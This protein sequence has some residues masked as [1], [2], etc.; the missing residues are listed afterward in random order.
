MSN[1]S[2]AIEWSQHTLLGFC[3][4][5]SCAFEKTKDQSKDKAKRGKPLIENQSLSDCSRLN[6]E[7]FS[8]RLLCNASMHCKHTFHQPVDV[9]SLP[10]PLFCSSVWTP[11]RWQTH[12]FVFMMPCTLLVL[13]S[14]NDIH[15]SS[16]TFQSNISQLEWKRNSFSLGLAFLHQQIPLEIRKEA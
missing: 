8:V 4:L 11:D 13:V 10:F 5:N 2:N 15:I 3:I 6:T 7:L 1:S 12:Y 14:C 9:S 16:V